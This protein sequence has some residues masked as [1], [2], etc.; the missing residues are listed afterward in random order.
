MSARCKLSPTDRSVTFVQPFK[1]QPG[2]SCAAAA[3]QVTKA[4]TLETKDESADTEI[5]KSRVPVAGFVQNPA[6]NAVECRAQLL[7]PPGDR[8]LGVSADRASDPF[9]GPSMIDFI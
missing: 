9:G 7:L 5:W 6:R 4:E 2:R 1:H 3:P 8:R